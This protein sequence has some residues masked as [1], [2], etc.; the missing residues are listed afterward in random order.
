MLL[1]WMCRCAVAAARLVEQRRGRIFSAMGVLFVTGW[2]GRV[3]C[4]SWLAAVC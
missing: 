1:F 4:G 3:C 2:T